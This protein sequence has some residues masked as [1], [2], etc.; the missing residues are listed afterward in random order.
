M[1]EP[2]LTIALTFDSDAI[3]DGIRRGDSPVKLSHAEFGHRVGVPRILELLG[4]ERA[5][6]RLRAALA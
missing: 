5:L 3:S 2:R 1:T 4:R 6:G